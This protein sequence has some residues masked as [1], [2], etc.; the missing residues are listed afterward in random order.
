MNTLPQTISNCVDICSVAESCV[1]VTFQDSTQ[2]CSYYNDV[3]GSVLLDGFDSAVRVEDNGNGNGAGAGSTTTTTTVIAPGVTST[4]IVGAAT[5]A[6]VYTTIVST[7]TVIA[8]GAGQ[9]GVALPSGAVVTEIVSV[10]EAVYTNT[11][12]AV[13]MAIPTITVTAGSGS[14][15]GAAVATSYVTVTVDAA[16]NVVGGSGSGSGAGA[17]AG[18]YPTVTVYQ[19]VCST[20]AAAAAVETTW[21]TVFV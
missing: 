19:Q 10:G 17:A 9:T 15:A 21:T 20:P 13:N 3:T 1:G 12:P 18:A 7:V 16:G 11:V 2:T 14:G 5:T 6:T 8:G 4:V